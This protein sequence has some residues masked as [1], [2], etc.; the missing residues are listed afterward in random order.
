MDTSAKQIVLKVEASVFSKQLGDPVRKGELLGR[1]AGDEVIAPCNGTI[2][3]VSFD[4][5]DHVFMV[6]IEQAS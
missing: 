6:V 5:V 1:F 2:K 3:G 4:P